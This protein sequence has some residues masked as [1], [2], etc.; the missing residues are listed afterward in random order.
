MTTTCPSCGCH[1]P[2]GLLCWQCS[3]AVTTMWA[4]APQLVDQLQ[5]AISKQAKIGNTGKAG[6]G[7][8]H[9][10][11]PIN[12]GPIAARDALM[13]EVATWGG[14]IDLVRK[15][16]Q[17]AEIVR[18]LGKAV[19]DAYR[20]IDRMQDR[21][22]LGTCLVTEDETVCHAEIWVKPGAHQVTCTQCETT[23]DV[24]ARRA[25]LLEQAADLIVTPREASQYVGEVGGIAVGHQ[26]IRNYLD[27]SRI[28]TRPASDGV[29][30]LR[31]GDLLE[32]LLD[33]SA[34]HDA[35]AS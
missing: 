13:V 29:L 5:V 19:K 18:D 28:A 15:H 20:A 12:W 17:A 4:A 32:I 31:L 16:P 9:E 35:R 3:D 30:R 10:R 22:Y 11:L 34:R 8:A 1:Q 6:K 24:L 14:D 33:E 2:E 7:S 23:H 25:K 21:Q 26:R 27:R